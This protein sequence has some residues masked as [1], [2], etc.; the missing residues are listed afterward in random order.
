MQ[1]CVC[2][3]VITVCLS[4][5]F[6]GV[7]GGEEMLEINPRASHMVGRYSTT[8]LHTQLMKFQMYINETALLYLKIY[9]KLHVNDKL[10]CTEDKNY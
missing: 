7:E 8:K 4:C 9:L 5:L 2:N 6:G 3:L 1:S 10:F